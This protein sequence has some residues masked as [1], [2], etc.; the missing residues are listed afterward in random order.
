MT[1]LR[2]LVPRFVVG[3]RFSRLKAGSEARLETAQ[4]WYYDNRDW[5]WYPFAGI[6][7]VLFT[8]LIVM[9]FLN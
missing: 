4:N 9:R 3:T 6:V 5:V 2:I 7:A 8:G 1:G